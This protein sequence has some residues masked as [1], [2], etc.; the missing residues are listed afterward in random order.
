MQENITEYQGRKAAGKAYAH[1]LGKVRPEPSRDVG[2]FV[3]ATELA[4]AEGRLDEFLTGRFIPPGWW[5]PMRPIELSVLDDQVFLEDG[6]HRL[7]A[8]KKA[9]GKQILALVIPR[10]ERIGLQLSAA[11]AVIL[12][13]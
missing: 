13:L 12:P 8:A 7:Y 10:D 4:K 5:L 2:P 3:K 9:G 11:E 6:N 1:L